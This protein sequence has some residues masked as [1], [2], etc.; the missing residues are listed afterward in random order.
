LI[1]IETTNGWDRTPFHIS[2]NELAVVEERPSEWRLL[3]LWNFSREP[4]AFE[5]ALPLTAHVSWAATAFQAT[6]N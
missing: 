3:R 5:I 1:E 4:R 6:F 2:R